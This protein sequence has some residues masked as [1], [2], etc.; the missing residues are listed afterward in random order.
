MALEG[1][2][3]TKWEGWEGQRDDMFGFGLAGFF[4]FATSHGLLTS[5]WELIRLIKLIKV[6]WRRLHFWVKG[7][8]VPH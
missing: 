3:V 8:V 1:G 5:R 2:A 6:N 4:K 7:A